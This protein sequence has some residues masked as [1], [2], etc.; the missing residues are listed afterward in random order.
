MKSGGNQAQDSM[1]PLLVESCRTHN[2]LSNEMQQ[3]MPSV[4]QRSSLEIVLR[5][6]IGGWLHG[7]PLSS[8][9]SRPPFQK[10]G[11]MVSINH[12]ICTNSLGTMSHFYQ[13]VRTFLKF[14]FPDT[15]PRPTL[16]AGISKASSQV[17]Y[18]NPSLH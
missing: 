14:R 13:L 11:I 9:D 7:H 6:F 16:Q 1:S 15:T 5:V 17:G 2:S 12:S 18:V 3:H 10:E 4:S 8:V